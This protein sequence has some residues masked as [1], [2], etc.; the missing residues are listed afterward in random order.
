[1]RILKQIYGIARSCWPEIQGRVRVLTDEGM[2]IDSGACLLHDA[3]D[4]A[5]KWVR[6]RDQGFKIGPFISPD[7]IDKVEDKA[8]WKEFL[9]RGLGV[10]AGASPEDIER[11]AEWLTERRLVQ[12]GFKIMSRG[13][14]GYDLLVEGNRG[15]IYM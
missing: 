2:L 12:R 4:P 14:K 9:V 5:E 13:G 8:I 1:M 11:F 10:K 15:D 6:W 3:Y 7:Y